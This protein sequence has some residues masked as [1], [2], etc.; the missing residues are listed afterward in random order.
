MADDALIHSSIINLS[1]ALFKFLLAILNR[2]KQLINNLNANSSNSNCNSKDIIVQINY[3]RI[4]PWSIHLKQPDKYQLV[5]L[6]RFKKK[7]N[8]T[9]SSLALNRICS[10]KDE[11]IINRLRIGHTYAAHNHLMARKNPPICETCEVEVTVKHIIID[12]SMYV[13]SRSKHSIPYQLSEA[14]QSDLQSKINIYVPKTTEY[15]MCS[16]DYSD[17]NIFND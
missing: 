3:E 7:N 13:D 6:L 9:V 10:V 1:K 16:K 15:G 14:L 2:N 12:C 17:S 5:T 4:D 8:N 11:T